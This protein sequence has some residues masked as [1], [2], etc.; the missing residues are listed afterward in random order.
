[1]STDV[2]KPKPESN[3]KTQLVF[4][5]QDCGQSL[6]DDQGQLCY[7]PKIYI[8]HDDPVRYNVRIYC[9]ARF[10]NIGVVPVIPLHVEISNKIYPLPL[11]I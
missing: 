1:M 2:G 6:Y 3:V 5:G 10:R 7:T 8:I 11:A 9:S 4:L